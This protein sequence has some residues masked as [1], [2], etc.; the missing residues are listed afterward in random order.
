MTIIVDGFIIF[1]RIV[2]I[3]LEKR[4]SL[5]EGIVAEKVK[6]DVELITMW[7]AGEI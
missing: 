6:V 5:C 4:R 3:R 7:D 2:R 1:F